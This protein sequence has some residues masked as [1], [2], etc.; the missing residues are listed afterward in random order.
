[1]IAIG[2]PDN[3]EMIH[4]AMRIE[5]LGIGVDASNLSP[6]RTLERVNEMVTDQNL[7]II[8][9]ILQLRTGGLQQTVNY[10]QNQLPCTL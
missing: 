1:M 6:E 9:N 2:E 5:A 10:L 8:S 7:I 4:N 3:P